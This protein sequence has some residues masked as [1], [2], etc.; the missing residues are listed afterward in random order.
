MPT[1]IATKIGMTRV[2]TELGVSIPVTVLQ[3]ADHK[4]VQI[5]TASKD[6]YEAY[7]IGTHTVKHLNKA[8]SAH[9]SS[10]GIEEKYGDL[11]E[12]SRDDFSRELSEGDSLG[13]SEYESDEVTFVDVSGL[14][15][16]RGFTGVIKR[17]GFK[18]QPATHGNSLSGRVTGSLGAN[19]DPGR[20]WKNKK[21]PGRYGH[22]KITVQ[23][24]KVVR[25]DT[26]RGL[27][28]VKGPVPGA[29]GFRVLV[30]RA[31]KK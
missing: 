17:W 4:V 3:F 13:V 20:V 19:Q 29:N 11:Y 10:H 28:L 15:K 9:L 5:K 1:L 26:E 7:Q 12:V 22:T 27:L 8:E 31:V 21:M 25:I 6:G 16:G 18:T 24:L 2:F 14:S 23:S 30:S